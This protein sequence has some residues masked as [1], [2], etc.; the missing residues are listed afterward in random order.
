MSENN[1]ISCFTELAQHFLVCV[2]IHKARNLSIM[3]ADTFTLVSLEK[4]QKRTATFKNSDCPY[5]NEVTT[6]SI[7]MFIINSI[8]I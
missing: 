2:T 3:N 7:P 5:F 8:I 1:L 4:Q 6:I